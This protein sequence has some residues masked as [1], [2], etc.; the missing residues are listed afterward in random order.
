MNL[1]NKLTVLRVILVPFF[2]FFL[3]YDFI[4]HHNLIA[5]IIFAANYT[6]ISVKKAHPPDAGIVV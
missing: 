5:L 3:L 6:T 2:V 4:P 1:P